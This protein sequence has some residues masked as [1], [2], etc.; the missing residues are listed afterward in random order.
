LLDA[1]RVISRELF[2]FGDDADAFET[3]FTIDPHKPELRLTTSLATRAQT[4]WITRVLANATDR[5]EGPPD[6]FYRLPKDSMSAWWG[7]AADPG[8]FAGMRRILHKGLSAFFSMPLPDVSSADKQAFLAW[9]DGLPAISGVWVGSSGLLPHAKGRDKILTAPQ[10][11]EEAKN[12][13]RTYLPWGIGGGD[14]DPAP[15]IAWMKLSEDAFNRGVAAIKRGSKKD[16]GVPGWLPTV[17]FVRD[18]PGYPKGSAALD[19]GIAFSSKDVWE[20]LPQNKRRELSPGN[21]GQPE[22]PKGPEA[23][24][25]VTLRVVVVPEDGGQ[26]WWGYSTDLA[27]LKSHVS[28]VLRNAPAA[29]QLSDRTDLE[30]L[31]SHKGFGGFVSYSSFIDMFRNS[32]ALAA[33]DR[34]EIDDTINALPHK[35]RGAVYM[36]GSS[37]GGSAPIFSVDLVAGKDMFEDLSAA[38]SLGMTAGKTRATPH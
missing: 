29:G 22:H 28:R 24:G 20:F 2:A 21:W 10:A 37:T 14:G 38:I 26:Y 17:K 25:K 6:R 36:L 7:R 9:V 3:A 31:K 1:P 4:S 11:V 8:Q 19:I 34:K 12:L 15:F 13:A 16:G 33:S 35:G 30:I 5:P 23:K 18:A 27:E 32:D